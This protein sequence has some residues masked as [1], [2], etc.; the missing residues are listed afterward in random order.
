MPQV[1]QKA[2]SYVSCIDW[3]GVSPSSE[4]ISGGMRWT[5]TGSTTHTI[6]VRH[7]DG[8]SQEITGNGEI[9]VTRYDGSVYDFY[10]A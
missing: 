1:E 6:F 7:S 4:A 5:W 9:V 10:G 8:S 3:S 2:I